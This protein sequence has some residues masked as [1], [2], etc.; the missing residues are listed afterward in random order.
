VI[1]FKISNP[2]VNDYK[3]NYKLIKFQRLLIY[4]DAFYEIPD[5]TIMSNNYFLLGSFVL[6]II[7]DEIFCWLSRLWLLSKVTGG[8]HN[9]ESKS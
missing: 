1:W 3:S 4:G 7:I 6:D 8:I 2:F 9:T 5:D